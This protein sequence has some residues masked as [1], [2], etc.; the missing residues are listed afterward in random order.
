MIGA[1]SDTL[2]KSPVT[3]RHLHPLMPDYQ[4]P[5]RLELKNMNDAFGQA[6]SVQAAIL[7]RADE[8]NSAI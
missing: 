6:N 3:E 8:R 2:K 7:K 1:Q 4:F 5:G